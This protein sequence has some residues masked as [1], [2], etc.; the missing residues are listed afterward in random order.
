[1][2]ALGRGANPWGIHVVEI[3]IP[4]RFMVKVHYFMFDKRT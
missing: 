1:M 2:A 3:Y 4:Y